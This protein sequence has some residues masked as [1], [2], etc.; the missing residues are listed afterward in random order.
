MTG[1]KRSLIYWG[2]NIEKFFLTMLLLSAVMLGIMSF[3]NGEIAY[4]YVLIY[5]PMIFAI[6]FLSLAYTN[7]TTSLSHIISMGATRRDSF[8]GMQ[9]FYHLLVIQGIVVTGIVI[10]LLPEFYATD[11]L[12][13][14]KYFMALYIFS[15]TTGNG[16]SIVV[17]RYGMNTA[18]IIYIGGM[19]VISMLEVI[20]MMISQHMIIPY[21]GTVSVVVIMVGLILDAVSIM[22]CS[23]AVKEYE[24]RV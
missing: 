4:E 10:G 19:I 7:I 13:L 12:S 23:K 20:I 11:N 8:L 17:M 3:L 6:A 22:I 5:I 2:I 1:L 21:L 14:C 24:V 15:C 18:K 16:I 9:I